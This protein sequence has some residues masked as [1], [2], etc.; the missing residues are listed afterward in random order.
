MSFVPLTVS[1]I[2]SLLKLVRVIGSPDAVLRAIAGD[3]IERRLQSAWLKP[4][5][6]GPDRDRRPT[7]ASE[8]T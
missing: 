5:G 1:A 3:L 6:R 2:P 8:L 7:I 4:F